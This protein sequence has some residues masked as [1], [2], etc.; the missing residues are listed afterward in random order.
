MVF[1]PPRKVYAHEDLG[2]ADRARLFVLDL[3]SIT[4]YVLGYGM[5]VYIPHTRA[6][7]ACRAGRLRPVREE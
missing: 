6:P 1:L 2:K 4:V 7:R 3:V 5:S